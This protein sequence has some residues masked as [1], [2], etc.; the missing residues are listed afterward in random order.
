MVLPYSAASAKVGCSLQ[1]STL[2][3]KALSDLVV[4]SNS[5]SPISRQESSRA[6]VRLVASRLEDGICIMCL[7]SGLPSE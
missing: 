6:S 1:R 4:A 3:S 7:I 2:L 5:L